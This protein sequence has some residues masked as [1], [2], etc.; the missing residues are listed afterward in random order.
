MNALGADSVRGVIG[1]ALSRIAAIFV[2]V[3]NQ[4][5]PYTP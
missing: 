1:D 4:L 2:E 5:D 3:R